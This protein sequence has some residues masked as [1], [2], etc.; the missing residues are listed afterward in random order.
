MGKAASTF[1]KE[2]GNKKIDEAKIL[3]SIDAQIQAGKLPETDKICPECL[4]K[5]NTITAG[6]QQ[7]ECCVYC[8]S[9]W[10]DTGELKSLTNLL[11]DIPA[12]NLAHRK[13]QRNCPVCQAQMREYL[14]VSRQNLLID[15]CP[16]EHGVYLQSGELK[17]VFDLI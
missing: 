12:D 5:L 8:K 7:I 17:R 15:K 16:N 4:R 9:L 13:S 6:E 14:F 2:C 10:F 1:M 11:R 3:A